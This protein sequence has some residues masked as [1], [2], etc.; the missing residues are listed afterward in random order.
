MSPVKNPLCH[1]IQV[2]PVHEMWANSLNTSAGRVRDRSTASD[3]VRLMAKMY[4]AALGAE[5]AKPGRYCL[6][7][8]TFMVWKEQTIR[9]LALGKGGRVTVKRNTF[10]C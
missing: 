10:S 4:C 7:L 5:M 1:N 9:N 8:I 3:D 6:L 2:F